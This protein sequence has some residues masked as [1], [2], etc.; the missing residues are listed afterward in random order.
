VY[1]RPNNRSKGPPLKEGKKK[2]NYFVAGLDIFFIPAIL[3]PDGKC[4]KHFYLL[5]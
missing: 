5:L 1:K 2:E 4:P 3:L